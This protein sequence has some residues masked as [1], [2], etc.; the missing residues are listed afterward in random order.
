MKPESRR[1]LNALLRRH[2]AII[3]GNIDASVID[4]CVVSYADLCEFA[5]LDRALAHPSGNFLI[6]I[7]EWCIGR[8]L[9]PINALAV[10]EYTRIPGEGYP[11]RDRCWATD[12]ENVI[13]CTE[14][15]PEI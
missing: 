15:P 9:P 4:C 11:N 2:H 12:V 3:N 7:H 13:S 6:E 10:N 1:L 14:Y 5:G 8:G